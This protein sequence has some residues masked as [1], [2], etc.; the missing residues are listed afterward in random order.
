MFTRSDSNQKGFTLIVLLVALVII[1]A[2]F[3]GFYFSKNKNEISTPEGQ[4]K[5][6]KQAEIDIDAVNQATR[7]RAEAAGTEE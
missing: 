2:I 5:A 1:A 4:I 3:S 6:L 7:D